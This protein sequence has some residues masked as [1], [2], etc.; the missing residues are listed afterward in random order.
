MWQNGHHDKRFDP[1]RKGFLLSAEREAHWDPPHFLAQFGLR[2]GQAVLDL[3]AGPGFWTL[4]LADLVGPQGSVFALDVSRELLDDLADRNPPP[5]VQLV[6]SVLPRINLADDA[7][8]FAWA[9][10]VYHEVEPGEKLAAELRR[11]VKP[12]GRVAVLEWRPDAVG[13]AGPPRAHR[14][15]PAQVVDWLAAAGF[16]RPA[17]TWQDEDSYLVQSDGVTGAG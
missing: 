4:P 3:G 9:A 5:Q 6:Q 2:P 13:E 10:F 12:R 1:R 7:V 17:L 8:G 14:L 11:V 15:Q 16:V